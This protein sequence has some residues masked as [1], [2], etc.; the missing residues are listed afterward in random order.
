STNRTPSRT[1]RAVLNLATSAPTMRGHRSTASARRSE[2]FIPLRRNSSLSRAPTGLTPSSRTQHPLEPYFTVGDVEQR[3]VP[4]R[5]VGPT[6]E[7]L[8]CVR[9]Q[10]E[11]V[12][13]AGGVEFG[14]EVIDEEYRRLSV[15]FVEQPVLRHLQC[16]RG[17][18][19][20]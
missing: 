18:A 12:G 9:H 15:P 1:L 14:R 17:R 11:K 20:L 7:R 3:V 16:Q 19:G 13:P 8:G 10:V 4:A 6:D 2:R 5:C